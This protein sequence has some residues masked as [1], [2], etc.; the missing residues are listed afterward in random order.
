MDSGLAFTDKQKAALRAAF[1]YGSVST[2]KR[3]GHDRQTVRSLV[4][5][6]ILRKTYDSPARYALTGIGFATAEWLLKLGML[7][8]DRKAKDYF[9][10]TPRRKAGPILPYRD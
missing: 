9:G 3:W 1:D 10:K 6:G 8:E 2:H 7:D 5:R 4:S